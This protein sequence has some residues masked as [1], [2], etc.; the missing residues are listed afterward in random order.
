MRLGTTCSKLQ[1]LALFLSHSLP[2]LELGWSSILLSSKE[3]M[4][5]KRR[6]DTTNTPQGRKVTS[7]AQGDFVKGFLLQASEHVNHVQRWPP[8][9]TLSYLFR[10][11]CWALLCLEM[12]NFRVHTSYFP[13]RLNILY[14]H[15]G[16]KAD[17]VSWKTASPMMENYQVRTS[18]GQLV[19]NRC[20]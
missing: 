19:N 3:G 20:W 2:K 4:G 12:I 9:H 11:S 17:R 13:I 10:T 14:E 6:R 1:S 15:R 18:R 5:P 16:K 7:P 8:L